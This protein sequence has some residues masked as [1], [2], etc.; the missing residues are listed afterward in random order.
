MIWAFDHLVLRE[1]YIHWAVLKGELLGMVIWV[2]VKQQKQNIFGG[3]R[4]IKHEAPHA[5]APWIGQPVERVTDNVLSF[6]YSMG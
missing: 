1:L 4:I 3:V 5:T 2:S 6:P